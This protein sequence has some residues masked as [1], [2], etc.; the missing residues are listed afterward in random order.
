M[1][2]RLKKCFGAELLTKTGWNPSKAEVEY[3]PD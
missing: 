2:K 1:T 3:R